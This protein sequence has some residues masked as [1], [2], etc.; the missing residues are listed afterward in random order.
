MRRDAKHL[1]YVV[2]DLVRKIA[3]LEDEIWEKQGELRLAT[4]RL[5][6]T[7][8]ELREAKIREAGP[9]SLLRALRNEQ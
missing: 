2:D 1:Q 8:Q 4:R 7:K 6:C 9:D 3:Q 5:E